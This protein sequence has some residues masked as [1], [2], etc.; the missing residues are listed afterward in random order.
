MSTVRFF[1]QFVL[2]ATLALMATACGPTYPNCENDDHCADK[3]EYCLNNT[4]SQCRDNSHCEGAGMQCSSGRCDRIPG[5]CD[6]A[7]TCSGRQKCRDN[8][9]GAECLG[10]NE[11]AGT[12]FCDGG[13]CTTK[14]E[15]GPNADNPECPEGKEC[16]GGSCQIQI[17]QCGGTPIYFDFDRSTIKGSQKESLESVAACLKGDNVAPVTLEG[18]C[19]ERGTEEYNMALGERRADAARKYLVRKGVDENKLSTI[20]Y[21]KERPASLGSNEGSWSKNRRTEFVPR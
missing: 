21:G 17:A 5:Y 18:H 14:P 15:C 1:A 8:R 7:V 9:C 6:E 12:E 11:C 20:S 4:C 16:V 3:G 10:N 2:T 13:S 19:D